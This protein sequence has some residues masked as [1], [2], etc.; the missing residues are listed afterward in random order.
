MWRAGKYILTFPPNDP[1]GKG[2]Q[3]KKEEKREKRKKKKKEKE[4]KKEKRRRGKI[5]NK[6]GKKERLTIK[7]LNSFPAMLIFL[8][9]NLEREEKGEEISS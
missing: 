6:M 2:N 1:T 3:K 4:K 8:P 9:F 5:E 7:L